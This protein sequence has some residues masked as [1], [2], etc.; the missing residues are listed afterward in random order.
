MNLAVRRDADDALALIEAVHTGGRPL[1]AEYPL[2]FD[3]EG[4][5]R[6]VVAEQAGAV[7]ST[8]AILERDLVFP[9]AEGVERRLRAGLIGS[10][11]TSPDARGRGLASA[12]L[13]R[14]E[15]ELRASG[16]ALAILWAEAPEF[17]ARRGYAEFGVEQDLLL[18]RDLVERLPAGPAVT[19]PSAADLA[20]MHA[21]Y[22]AHPR[23]VE[24]GEA[25]SA[26]L[27]ATPG[28][29]TL[30]ARDAAG[31]AAAYLCCGRGHDLAHVVHEWAGDEDGVLACLRVLL[32][33]EAA[34]EHYLMAPPD[35]AGLAG[36][37]RE[38]G[39]PCC[40]GVLGM[41]KLLDPELALAELA[42]ASTRP[43]ERRLRADGGLRVAT[44]LGGVDLTAA[45]LLEL[46]AP[47]RFDC[48]A[49]E[50][51]EACLGTRFAGLPWAPFLW[52][53]DSI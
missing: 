33:T 52:G 6:V 2:V 32:A 37:L 10:V 40:N 49:I 17:Y 28:M 21:L 5:G 44:D 25:E 30:V 8:C 53:L 29:R 46:L 9:D 39:A 47:A 41:A 19:P 7:A 4:A 26:A 50:R 13:E 51:L 36:R 45:E 38:L 12:V 27:Y 35:L 18:T 20:A 43:L 24:R 16:C 3:A 34:E 48:A 14:A 15:A 42:R 1:A 31:S 22:A 11:S 23:R